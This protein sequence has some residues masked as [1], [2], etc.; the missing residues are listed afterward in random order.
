MTA[1]PRKSASAKDK[2]PKRA[3]PATGRWDRSQTSEERSQAQR[4]AILF[5]AAE[6][7]GQHGFFGTRVEHV[8]QASHKSRRTVFEHFATLDEVFV[9]LHAYVAELALTTVKAAVEG[10]KSP[11][12]RILRA[13][14][15]Y[16][17]LSRT[18][19]PFT[20]ALFLQKSA[21]GPAH[22]VHREQVLSAMANLLID[23]VREAHPKRTFSLLEAR[24]VVSAIETGTVLLLDEE[25]WVAGRE[26]VTN[27]VLAALRIE[28]N[29][30]R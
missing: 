20:R 5:G 7:I 12:E 27:L 16:V 25:D 24:V 3:A 30:R 21:L 19:I 18:N 23:T 14:A 15:A 13:V 11:K 10:A 9:E 26:R 22:D 8:V 28:D 2:P 29:E 6:A 1:R 4:Q 17:E